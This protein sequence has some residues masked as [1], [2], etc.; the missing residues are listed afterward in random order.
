MCGFQSVSF[1]ADTNVGAEVSWIL[2]NST[3][4]QVR[5]GSKDLVPKGIW[6][7]AIEVKGQPPGIYLLVVASGNQLSARKLVVE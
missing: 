1:H 3:G 7:Q 6:H 5:N 2:F 4:Q